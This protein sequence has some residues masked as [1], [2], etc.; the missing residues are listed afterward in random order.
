MTI[1]LK[2][3]NLIAIPV[4]ENATD[5]DFVNT[6]TKVLTHSL[7]QVELG[8]PTLGKYRFIGT[9]SKDLS[10]N[11]SPILTNQI[12]SLLQANGAYFVNPFGAKK[13]TI[14]K[15]FDHLHNSLDEKLIKEGAERRNKWQ[16]AQ[17]RTSNVWA[18]L[19]KATTPSP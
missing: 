3:T 13:P 19:E 16:S 12:R 18:I 17:L 2:P 7:G 9:I 8:L 15:P 10:K 5:F 11:M 6:H 14:F 4:P 1:E